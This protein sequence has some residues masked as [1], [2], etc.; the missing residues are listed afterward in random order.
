MAEP[1]LRLRRIADWIREELDRDPGL[2]SN[3]A[4]LE[5]FTKSTLECDQ[6]DEM[7]ETGFPR[8]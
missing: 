4:P 5:S 7:A 6:S 3:G 1:T 2:A 8:P